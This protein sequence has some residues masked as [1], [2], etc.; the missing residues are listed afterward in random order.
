MPKIEVNEKTFYDLLGRVPDTQTLEDLLVVAKAELKDRVPEEGLL[1]ID[2]ADTN[3]PDLW[4]TAGLARQLANALEGGS[5]SYD[6]FSSKTRTRE[7]D[8]RIV[9]VDA[10]V[11]D[12]RPFIC[13]FVAKGRGLNETLLKDLIRSQEKLCRSFGRKRRTIAMG[14]YRAGLISYPI[15]YEAV[16]PDN[17]SFVPLDMEEPLSLRE[18]LLK[19][20][21]GIEFGF[22]VEDLPLFPY[23]TD[24]NGETLSFPP[25]INSASL[26][27]VEV[28]DDHL[29][30]ELTGPDLESLLLATSISACDLA[31]LGFEILPV[32]VEY[33]FDTPY[34]RQI[35]TPYYFQ[36]PLSAEAG[37]TSRL[38]GVELDSE[39]MGRLLRSIGH[40]VKVGEKGV[41]LSPPEYRNDFLHA[42][43]VV[44]EVMV[45]RG[46]NS[47]EPVMPEDYTIGRLSKMELFTRRVRE[48][49]VGLAF[50][51]MVY[52]YLGSRKDFIERMN[53]TD[54]GFI[55]I[56]N[57]MTENYAFV[58]NS[59][60]PNLLSSESV[61]S[62]AV[63]P[64]KIFEIGK[65]VFKD[66]T[67][68]Y[69]SQ[70]RNFLGLLHAE[71]EVGFN[72]ISSQISAL[73]FFLSRQYSVEETEDPRFISGRTARI[74]YQKRP[75]GIMGEIAPG[76][77]SNWGI[78]IPCIGAEIDLDYLLE[79]EG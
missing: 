75:V 23:L 18:I 67:N 36:E 45:A 70:T 5:K 63:Y 38:L 27:A 22:I 9:W 77:L 19:H 62:Y 3:R 16:D 61:S 60:L 4:S 74:L 42:V 52:F 39:E 33:P 25:V 30:V 76:I 29:F 13:A 71:N 55:E 1:K 50:Q 53:L 26:G 72:E 48:I 34:G 43:D 24:L 57:P 21:K 58:R 66:P 47:F 31:D 65:V 54:E 14:V 41:T 20:P 32:R 28:G 10:S 79:D 7:T 44:E 40:R 69:G 17:T 46:M 12:I 2:L 64:H 11:R 15:T 8:G 56:E 78:R 37:Y 51:E 73:F 59:I 35:V 6:F 49:M 68:N